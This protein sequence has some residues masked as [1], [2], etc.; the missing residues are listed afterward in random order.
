MFEFMT[1]AAAIWAGCWGLKQW[2]GYLERQKTMERLERMAREA[3]ETVDPAEIEEAARQICSIE[4]Q[5][6][7]GMSTM[8]KCLIAT[9]ALIYIVFPGDFDFI[10]VIGWVDDV[11]V[12]YY[13]YKAINGK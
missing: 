3:G 10:P 6:A 9:G 11:A 12:G 4:H 7:G 8:T 5:P 1:L 13:A 2:L